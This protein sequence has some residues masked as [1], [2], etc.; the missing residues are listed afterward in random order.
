MKEKYSSIA[1]NTKVKVATMQN[2]LKH[3]ISTRTQDIRKHKN[4][5]YKQICDTAED[6]RKSV[7]TQ[8]GTLFRLKENTVQ[9]TNHLRTFS[10][11]RG[12]GVM[13]LK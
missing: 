8:L 12:I 13:R 4:D 1:A 3:E 7:S 10:D 9:S 6:G 5:M 2:E 11:L